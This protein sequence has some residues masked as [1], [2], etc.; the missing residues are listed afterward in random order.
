MTEIEA[1]RRYT[2]ARCWRHI[3]ERTR[4]FQSLQYAAVGGWRIFNPA[5]KPRQTPE[6][7][8]A[9]T[10][11][12]RAAGLCIQ[13]GYPCSTW[14]CRTCTRGNELRKKQVRLAAMEDAV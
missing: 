3:P 13:C 9:Y 4:S 11:R 1:V 7:Q 5:D 14:R 12:R 8:R 10:A 2:I 6:Y